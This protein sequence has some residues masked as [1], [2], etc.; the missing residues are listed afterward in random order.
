MP[1]LCKYNVP[2]ILPFSNL[3]EMES[4][5]LNVLM[6][7]PFLFSFYKICDFNYIPPQNP[8]LSSVFTDIEMNENNY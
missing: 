2:F 3:A 8:S 4:S 1:I 7:S 5:F 6:K